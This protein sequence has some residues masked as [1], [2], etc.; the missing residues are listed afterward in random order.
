MKHRTPLPPLTQRVRSA[1]RTAEQRGPHRTATAV[2]TAE[3][4]N[5][6]E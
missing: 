3:R 1:G 5:A 6:N 2:A 4:E